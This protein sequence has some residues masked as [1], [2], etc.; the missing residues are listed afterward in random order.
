[1][2]LVTNIFQEDNLKTEGRPIDEIYQSSSSHTYIGPVSYSSKVLNDECTQKVQL[3]MADFS[4]CQ[5]D[6]PEEHE[7]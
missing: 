1:M 2:S 5:S 6:W 4:I 3:L 7:W